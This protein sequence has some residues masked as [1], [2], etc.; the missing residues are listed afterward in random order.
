MPG[1]TN[2]VPDW[3]GA[4]EGLLPHPRREEV[5]LIGGMIGYTLKNVDQV[6][7]GI[8]L[9]QPTGDHPALDDADMLVTDVP[10]AKQPVLAVMQMLT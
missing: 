6:G 2:R 8:D 10:L 7:V 4:S 3:W 9:M 5:N 1:C